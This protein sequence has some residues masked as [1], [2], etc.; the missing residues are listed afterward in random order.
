MTDCIF[1]R[2]A[3]GEI[4]ADIIHQD[5]HALVFRDL[6]PQ[7]PQHLLAIPRKHIATLEA[8]TEADTVIVG[9][10]FQV[11]KA[12][13]EKVG[14]AASGYRTVLNNG[15]DAGQEVMHL[16][17]HILGGRRLTWPPG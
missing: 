16:H 14:I 15:R 6:R 11:A 4:P 8:L 5:E 1:C 12:A 3:Q 13:A 9:S 10:L 2:I 17:L 7:A